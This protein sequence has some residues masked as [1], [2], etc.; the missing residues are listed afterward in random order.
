MKR[1]VVNESEGV[2]GQL[3]VPGGGGTFTILIDEEIFGV[4]LPA[5]KRN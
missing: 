5:L 3:P 1:Y 4:R 2:K